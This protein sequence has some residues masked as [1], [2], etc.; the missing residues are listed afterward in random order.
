[1]KKFLDNKTTP[2]GGF[3]YKQSES[4]FEFRHIVFEEI[5]RRI[6]AHR[7]ANG[8][9]LSLGW[10]DRVEDEMCASMPPGICHHVEET[11]PTIARSIK[12]SDA[13]N[14]IKS[15]AYWV[16]HGGGFVEQE[17]ADRRAKIC[18]DCP[19]NVVIENCSGCSGLTRRISELIGPRTTPQAAGLRG[20]GV[21]GC[22]NKTQIWFPLE[23]LH[24]GINE[25]MNNKFPDWCWKRKEAL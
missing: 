4:G 20:C 16:S 19:H 11:P 5:M 25:E 7:A 15:M 17:E 2:P 12:V 13:I 24:K 9:D 14:F 3:Y 23:T 10:R 18:V 21:C 8:Y 22:E 6:R 1:M